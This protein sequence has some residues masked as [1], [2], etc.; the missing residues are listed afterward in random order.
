MIAFTV[1][2]ALV[3]LVLYRET[4]QATAKVRFYRMPYF[5]EEPD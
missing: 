4:R 1:N 3:F 5:S 2:W